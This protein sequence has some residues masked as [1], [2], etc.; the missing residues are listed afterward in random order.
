[1]I[2]EQGLTYTN[3]IQQIKTPTTIYEMYTI[4]NR[5]KR[6]NTYL[7][8]KYT[9]KTKIL[10]NSIFYK[11]LEIYS[12]ISDHIKSLDIKKFK[13]QIKIHISTS[14]DPYFLPSSPDDTDTETDTE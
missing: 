13:S 2:S 10:K 8:P 9:P 12:N 4:S 1:M 14:F 3:K 5:P 7:R 11:F 6:T